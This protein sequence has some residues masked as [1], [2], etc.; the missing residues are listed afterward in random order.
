MA[1]LIGFPSQSSLRDE[2]FLPLRSWTEVHGYLH[3]L[4]PR[5]QTTAPCH[6]PKTATNPGSIMKFFNQNPIPVWF[7]GVR[8]RFKLF[9]EARIR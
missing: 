4:A 5:G 6:P 9:R 2:T 1:H 3:C 8:P 7:L